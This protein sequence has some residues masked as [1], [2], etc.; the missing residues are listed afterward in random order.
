MP[1]LFSGELFADYHQI[2]L[3]DAGNPPWPDDYNEENLWRRVMIAPGVL[4]IHT[5][6]NMNV[7]VR[8]ELH[9]T[10]PDIDLAAFDHVA[11]T[12]IDCPSGKLV[13]AGITMYGGDPPLTVPAGRLGVIIT[14]AALAT[15]REN[16][17]EGDDH[18]AIHLWP[19]LHADTALRVLKQYEDPHIRP[20]K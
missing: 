7:P 12:A 6:R 16:D 18:Y 10:R 8:A 14:F 4:I 15:L 9:E 13:L 17:L 19:D 1:I 3:S 20:K 11:E 2:V 5:A